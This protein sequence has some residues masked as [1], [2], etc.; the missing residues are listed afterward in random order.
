[1]CSKSE[2]MDLI[3]HPE[4]IYE[5]INQVSSSRFGDEF[6]MIDNFKR[7]PNNLGLL[8]C[9]VKMVGS[10]ITLCKAGQLQYN[11]DCEEFILKP[12]DVLILLP[13]KIVEIQGGTPDAAWATISFGN[14]YIEQM[15]GNAD[16]QQFLQY[17]Y[18][19]PKITLGKE[20]FEE[21]LA[22]YY[23]LQSFLKPQSK[24]H[25]KMGIRG[26]LQV[27]FSLVIDIE[28]PK[29]ENLSR[30]KE[31]YYRFIALV[32]KD[33]NN[34]R[35]VGYYADRLCITPKYLSEVVKK[36]SSFLP[37]QIISHMVVLEAKAMIKTKRY[38]IAQISDYLDFANP[39][40]FAKYFKAHT[41]LTP[42]Q[43]LNQ[44]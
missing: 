27:F 8:H 18:V 31:I 38:T 11:V 6:I 12:N 21:I 32:Q 22:L 16:F 7:E 40:F 2:T 29:P 41:G 20:T 24:T 10:T 25:I 42:T 33:C 39:S 19:H 5:I 36:E 23:N 15:V 1:M 9:P 43:Y 30:S 44:G 4:E 14:N 13:G 35:S 26:Y 28:L 17:V 37:S 3:Q 34:E